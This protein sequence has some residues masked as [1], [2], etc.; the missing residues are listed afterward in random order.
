M[1]RLNVSSHVEYEEFIK[2]INLRYHLKMDITKLDEWHRVVFKYFSRIISGIMNDIYNTI[3]IILP[4][5]SI[6]V[7]LFNF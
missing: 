7:F 3:T 4:S 6:R 2:K 5:Q 1:C